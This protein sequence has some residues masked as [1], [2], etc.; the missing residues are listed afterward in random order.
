MNNTV[1]EVSKLIGIKALE[2]L[3]HPMCP[4]SLLSLCV[5]NIFLN[6]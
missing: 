2:F 5:S 4:M 3:D 1:Q 6:T